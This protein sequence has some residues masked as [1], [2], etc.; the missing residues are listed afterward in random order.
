MLQSSTQILCTQKLKPLLV[1]MCKCIAD[2]QGQ[3]KSGAVTAD[4][5]GARC[6]CAVVVVQRRS[7][8]SSGGFCR[9]GM[10]SNFKNGLG[11]CAHA[12]SVEERRGVATVY[13][14]SDLY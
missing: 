9:I 5:T 10:L 4:L 7:K 1:G 3:S 2:V 8:R 6:I 12:V 11:L 13:R 14:T